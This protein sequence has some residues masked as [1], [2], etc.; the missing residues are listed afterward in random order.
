MCRKEGLSLPRQ[1]SGLKEMAS[2]PI[3]SNPGEN[4]DI[5]QH[6]TSIS[7]RKTNPSCSCDVPFKEFGYKV[8]RKQVGKGKSQ[9][10]SRGSCVYVQAQRIKLHPVEYKRHLRNVGDFFFPIRAE[11]SVKTVEG[12]P[13]ELQELPG[14]FSTPTGTSSSP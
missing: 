8:H 1:P 14:F 9:I 11:K 7:Q 6:Q 10:N 4:R 12:T 13:V 3:G 5:K 2:N